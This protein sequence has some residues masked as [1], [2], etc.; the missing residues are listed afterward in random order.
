M[1]DAS[2]RS[3]SGATAKGVA[4]V[5]EGVSKRYGDHVV[6]DHLNL[7]VDAGAHVALIGPS[8]SGKTTVLRCMMGFE[9]IDEG[10]IHVGRETIIPATGG[11]ADQKRA[12]GGA[13]PRPFP[14]RYGLPTV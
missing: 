12:R 14:D 4:V 13:S 11:K 9:S 5:F 7:R 2:A 1:S 8:G 10:K 3:L 6:L